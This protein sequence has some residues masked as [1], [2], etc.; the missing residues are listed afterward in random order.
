MEIW[1]IL[2][3][4]VG[5]TWAH[6]PNNWYDVWEYFQ[7]DFPNFYSKFYL[8]NKKLN[9]QLPN[10]NEFLYKFKFAIQV[11]KEI[12]NSRVCATITYDSHVHFFMEMPI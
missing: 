4:K 3:I 12:G 1:R 9:F 11:E 2:S 5:F 7:Q 8:F 6:E 10:L